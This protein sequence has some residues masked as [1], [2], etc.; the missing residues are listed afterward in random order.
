[1]GTHLEPYH[2]GANYHPLCWA[3]G[4][5]VMVSLDAAEVMALVGIG[6]VKRTLE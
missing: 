3:T 2:R 4:G 1:M 6:I 5:G